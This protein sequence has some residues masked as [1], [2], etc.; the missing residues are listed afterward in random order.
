ML[1]NTNLYSDVGTLVVALE[2]VGKGSG[3]INQEEGADTTYQRR[4]GTSG[5]GVT[6]GKTN[7]GSSNC[8]YL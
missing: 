3:R 7:S 4:R 8:K 1:Y 2:K 6:R 5:K